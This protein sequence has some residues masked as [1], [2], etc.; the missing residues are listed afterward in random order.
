MRRR[1]NDDEWVRETISELSGASLQTLKAVL[2]N[3]IQEDVEVHQICLLVQELK[4]F[5]KEDRRRGKWQFHFPSREGYPSDP[6]LI[7]PLNRVYASEEFIRDLKF[8]LESA[9]LSLSALP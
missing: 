7:A 3:P 6:I 5:V 9:G 2:H 1:G 4:G 8:I